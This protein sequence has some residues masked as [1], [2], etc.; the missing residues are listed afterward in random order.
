MAE[1]RAQRRRAAIVAAD[2]VRYSTLME[3]GRTLHSKRSHPPDC[4]NIMS[5][6]WSDVWSGSWSCDN[7]LAG[8]LPDHD[9]Q[10]EHR[11][12]TLSKAILAG[13]HP[14]NLMA[15]GAPR[16]AAQKIPDSVRQGN[17]GCEEQEDCERDETSKFS[18][19]PMP[20][21]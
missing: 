18:R 13:A 6:D 19:P 15:L 20:T 3:Q 16:S 21:L 2:V 9:G 10:G 11:D 12:G 14:T 4:R 5:E 8:I 7:A 1:E 17:E